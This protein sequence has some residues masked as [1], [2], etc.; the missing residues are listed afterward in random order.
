[1]K[2]ACHFQAVFGV[3]KVSQVDVVLGMSTQTMG[4]VGTI[5]LIW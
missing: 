2:M 3:W 4:E 1:M 5:S